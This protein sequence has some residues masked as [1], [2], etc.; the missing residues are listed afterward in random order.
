M[1]RV[2]FGQCVMTAITC[3]K[4]RVAAEVVFL[5]NNVHAIYN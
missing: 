2:V 5:L 1:C 4:A 3:K